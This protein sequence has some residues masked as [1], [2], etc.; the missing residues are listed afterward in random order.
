MKAYRLVVRGLVQGV[1]FRPDVARIANSLNLKGYVKNVSG[2]SVEIWVEGER[3]EEFLEAL[4]SF[5][6]PAIIE[7]MKVEEVIAKGFDK[8]FIAKSEGVGTR[9]QVPP[10]FGICENCLREVLN[11]F[12]RR[13]GY[14][15]NSCAKCGPRFSMLYSLPYD[16]GNTSMRYFPLCAECQR[17]YEDPRDRRYHAQGISCA[18]CGPEVKLLDSEGRRVLVR[19]PIRE[20]SKLID[21]GFIVAIKGMGGYHLAVKATED[22][23]V[24]ELRKRKNRPRKPFALMALNIE[25]MNEIVEVKYEDVLNSPEA[26]ILLLPKKKPSPLSDL[27]APGHELIGVM[28]AYTAMHYLVLMNT[29]DKYS[30]MT[31]ANPTGKPTC[32]TKE[33][34]IEMEVADF[35]LEHDREIVHRV[36]DSVMRVT[37]GDLVFLRRSR[38]YA[39]KWIELPW[40]L[41]ELVALGAELQN[42]GAIS[43][44]N[45][46]ILTQYIGDTDE[47]E[48]LEFLENELKWFM[49][50]YSLKPLAVVSDL[51]PLYNTTNL[52]QNLSEELGIEHVQVQHHHAHVASAMAEWGEEE[53][54]GIA[55]DGTGYGTDGMIWGGE[56][57]KV[58]G[59]RFDRVCH[60]SYFPLPGG[61]RAAKYP[62]RI[63]LAILDI[64]GE[65]NEDLLKEL[66][67]RLPGGELEA[68]IALKQAKSSIFTSSAGRLLDAASALLGI[69]WERSYEGEPAMLL[70][71]KSFGGELIERIE[72]VRGSE[73]DV[74]EL[75]RWLLEARKKYKLKDVAYTFQ[76]N[77]GYNLGLCMRDYDLPKF[78]SG[79]AAVNEP[80]VKGAREA[81]GE[82]RLPRR[83][84]TGDGGIAL[85]QIAVASFRLWT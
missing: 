18:K 70:E 26:P 8:F 72:A 75:F 23:P 82:V 41:P 63:A 36:D 57:L 40:N 13:F 11:P 22:A 17:E 31:S 65:L 21:E 43:F 55:V 66:A 52:A 37:D 5:P 42:A 69:S 10:D 44:E 25:V 71:A 74:G 49:E 30:V 53:G 56:V 81:S 54:V 83:V 50:Q 2:G 60:L 45:K 12:S 14:A 67:L 33:C 29:E 78:M 62:A 68:R 46:V 61:D 84:P 35:I 39:P 24:R 38:G 3:V 59:D 9:S 16:R 27:V 64:I 51:H 48:A 76:Y 32:V 19:D 77:V 47:L 7:E 58:E 79:G 15:L 28:R 85:G 1:G 34:V 73:V 4:K 80:M 6:R 20:A